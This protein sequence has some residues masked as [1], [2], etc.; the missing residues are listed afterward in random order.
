MMLSLMACCLMHRSRAEA[1]L[2]AGRGSEIGDYLTTHPLVNCISFTGGDTGANPALKSL[3]LLCCVVHLSG[4]VTRVFHC[5]R[6]AAGLSICKKAGMV[7][8]QVCCPAFMTPHSPQAHS[9][10]SAARTCDGLHHGE[11]RQSIGMVS[12]AGAGVQMELGG[13]DVCIICEDADLDLAAKNII[14]GGFSYSGQRCTAVKLILVVESVADKL[15]GMVSKQV[16][17]L[18]VGK[19][20]VSDCCSL[21]VLHAPSRCIDSSSAGLANSQVVH[22]QRGRCQA[23]GMD[24]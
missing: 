2:A 13:K 9:L 18:S 19:P 21:R 15:V 24:E 1:I 5:L 16:D 17:G 10:A 14:K 8:I 6:V 4:S 12:V 11:Q 3:P 20:Q 7:P 23:R 22:A